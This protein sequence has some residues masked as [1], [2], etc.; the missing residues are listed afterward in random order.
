M[1]F[2]AQLV[3][4]QQ[5]LALFQQRGELEDAVARVVDL[6]QAVLAGLHLDDLPALGLVEELLGGRAWGHGVLDHRA[7][8]RLDDVAAQQL[9]PVALEEAAVG[10]DVG[11]D[12]FAVDGDNNADDV[13]AAQGALQGA[14]VVALE[15]AAG[16]VN[17]ALED[18]GVFQLGVARGPARP[19]ARAPAG[20]AGGQVVRHPRAH[21][22]VGLPDFLLVL[23]DGGLLADFGRGHQALAESLRGAAP[24]AGLDAE[25]VEREL[26]ARR[27]DAVFGDDAVL[28]AAGDDFAG[29]QNERPP[30]VVAE[31]QGVDL[32]L[33]GRRPA[34]PPADHRR[35]PFGGFHLA[36][37]HAVVE[38]PGAP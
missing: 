36:R 8:H 38:R 26:A 25:D 37:A 13:L 33:V 6:H 3:E 35:A 14:L 10:E 18:F 2:L 11:P 15:R 4:V 5:R 23:G 29:E 34:R 32:R 17:A 24:A 31:R 1:H 16:I 7:A 12:D 27:D 30:R 20:G 9:G 22:V 28:L 21:L 19:G